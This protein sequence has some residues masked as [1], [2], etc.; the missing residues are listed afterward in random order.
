MS[1][2]TLVVSATNVLAR[3]F[4]AVPTDR[5][6]RAGAPVNGLFAVA[7]AV[8]HVIAW[9]A[10]ETAVAS[11]ALDGRTHKALAAAR[12]ELPEHLARA[13]LDRVRSLPRALDECTYAPADAAALN[14]ALDALGFVE[15]LAS[16]AA[17]T[18]VAACAT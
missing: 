1:D 12:A 18:R 9:K 16:T 6:S 17:A 11:A 2:R 10:P 15:L 8:L 5:K 7:R 13:R 3:G 14:A 4:L